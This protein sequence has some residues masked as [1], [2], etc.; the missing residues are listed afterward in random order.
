MTSHINNLEFVKQNNYLSC[1]RKKNLS[2]LL[3]VKTSYT[4]FLQHQ[5]GRSQNLLKYSFMSYP[6][7]LRHNFFVQNLLASYVRD[8]WIERNLLMMPWDWTSLN[9]F[10][11]PKIFG[12]CVVDYIA[13]LIL[14]STCNISLL[15][16]KFTF[17]YKSSKVDV[18]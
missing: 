5:Y 13:W 12:P 16:P 3:Y 8:Y 11:K 18:S 4:L 1:I 10:S 9:Y 14:C 15:V 2:Y 6:H 17:V 7:S